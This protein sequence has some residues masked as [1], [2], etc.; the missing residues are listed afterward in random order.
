[1]IELK[2]VTKTY[3]GGVC[4]LKNVDLQIADGEFV[5]IVGGSGA[6]KSALA[7]LLIAEEKPSEGTITV[8][9]WELSA[10]KKKQI[11]F[12]RRRLGIVF[13][14]FR[15]FADK[16]VYEN[17]AFA[18]RV[19]GENFS[20]IRMKVGAALRMVE[21]TGKSKR[22]PG[23]LSVVEQQRVALARALAGSP[24]LIIADEPTGNTDPVQS[25]ELMELFGRIHSR[26]N[27][28]VVILTHDKDLALSFGMRTVCM[29][30]GQIVED[31]A[32]SRSDEE[33]YT[34]SQQTE[35]DASNESAEVFAPAHTQVFDAIELTEDVLSMLDADY[36]EPAQF[37]EETED[38]AEPAFEWIQTE[39]EE[40]EAE[41]TAEA[42]PEATVEFDAVETP[43]PV[44]EIAPPE[45]EVSEAIW[46]SSVEAHEAVAAATTE[47]IQ[48]AE[49]QS[50][51]ISTDALEAVL[52]DLLR[53]ISTDDKPASSGQDA[54]EEEEQT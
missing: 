3:P 45:T 28:T 6:G 1:M 35:T 9:S 48:G 21:L 23:E 14:D 38:G 8:G 10:L 17:V 40:V 47:T 54:A 50:M 13:R 5:F 7:K 43:V 36:V 16:T 4:A 22:Y 53:G 20:S 44:E 2:N 34:E 18:L 12:Y 30:H 31:I 27:K 49:V 15:L 29:T 24:D 19:I 33:L 46:T 52:A 11:P 41:E 25:R 26:Y 51:T 32:A 39:P 42:A 37:V